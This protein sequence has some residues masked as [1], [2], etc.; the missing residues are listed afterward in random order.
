MITLA[1]TKIYAHVIDESGIVDILSSKAGRS[2]RGRKP[3]FPNATRTMLVGLMLSMSKD[4]KATLS[5]THE[6]LTTRLSGEAQEF[7]EVRRP[8]GEVISEK[9]LYHT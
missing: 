9:I 4:G 5:A 6:L 3:A 1:E 2:T 7:L 8:N